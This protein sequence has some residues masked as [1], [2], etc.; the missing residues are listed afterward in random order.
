LYR[1]AHISD[2]HFGR[3]D[4]RI[5]EAL[6]ADLHVQAPSL[7]VVSGDLVQRPSRHSLAR[8]RDYLARLPQPTVTIAGNH[9]LPVFNLVRRFRAPFDRFQRYIEDDLSPHHVDDR[10]ALLGLSSA[11]A[12]VFDFARGRIDADQ[13]SVVAAFFDSQPRERLRILT[14]H[15]PLRPPPDQPWTP[16]VFGADAL[17][18]T[19]RRSRVDLVL[20]GHL[21][22]SF[23]R[24]LDDGGGDSGRLPDQSDILFQ[25]PL[26]CHAGTATS[27]R[28]RQEPQSYILLDLDRSEGFS[29]L[30]LRLRTWAGDGF[31]ERSRLV[32]HRQARG[33]TVA[34]RSGSD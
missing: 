9:D 31:V 20:S 4:E 30:T 33:W 1:L 12:L 7:V 2:L 23:V 26:L 28:L 34:S 13:R 17:A 10:V 15:H 25:G 29:Y 3:L 5:A 14:V 6:Q 24:R 8:A 16:L 22:R 19:L 18:E 21:H 32:L 11:K 27:T